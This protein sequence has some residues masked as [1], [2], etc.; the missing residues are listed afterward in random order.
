MVNRPTKRKKE[1]FSRV[2]KRETALLKDKKAR[3]IRET[4]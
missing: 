2:K 4:E 1:R 3:F